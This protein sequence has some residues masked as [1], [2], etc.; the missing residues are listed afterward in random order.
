MTELEKIAYAKSFIDKL[1]NGINPVDDSPVP[2]TDIV[3]NVRLTRCFFY[4]SDILRQVIDNKGVGFSK[5]KKKMPFHI[6]TEQLS[7][8]QFSEYPISISVITKQINECRKDETIAPL[9]YGVITKWLLRSGFLA[10]TE[11]SNGKHS[12]VPTEEGRKLGISTE[13]RTGQNGEYLAVLYDK[14]AQAFIIDN[15]EAIL[16]E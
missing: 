9:S 13:I 5:G 10:E 3:N 7:R 2:E 16:S 11:K 4:V 15:I 8:F 1:A 14:K 6:T 12:K